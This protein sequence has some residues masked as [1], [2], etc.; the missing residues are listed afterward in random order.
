AS[1]ATKTVASAAKPVTITFMEA[2]TSGTL[3][4]S[5]EHLTTQFEKTHPTITVKLLPESGYGTLEEKT[6]AAIAAN[7]P[8]TMVQSYESWN[9]A[10]SNYSA[11]LP[12]ITGNCGS[13]KLNMFNGGSKSKLDAHYD[14][15]STKG[16]IVYENVTVTLNNG[17]SESYDGPGPIFSATA[18]GQ[19]TFSGLRPKTTYRGTLTG[20]VTVDSGATCT[21]IPT[22]ATATTR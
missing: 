4:T 14:L 18:S 12:M 6:E 17:E 20:T 11:A 13:A 1:S 8:P 10:F 7:S 16:N 2:M 15:D 19:F 3:K 21:I 22:S 9:E 5:M